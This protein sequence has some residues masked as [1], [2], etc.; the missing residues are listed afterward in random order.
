M[1]SYLRS[2]HPYLHS[3]LPA[4]SLLT[5]TSCPC[6]ALPQAH[7]I[8]NRRLGKPTFNCALVEARWAG[9]ECEDGEGGSTG[10]SLE[11]GRR[12]R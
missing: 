6:P 3:C 5:L 1:R 2:H 11:V 9:M 12:R 4:S 10:C 7:N 8:V